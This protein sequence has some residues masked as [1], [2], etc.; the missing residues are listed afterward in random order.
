MEENTIRKI[1]E[2]YI[3]SEAAPVVTQWILENRVKFRITKN[4]TTKLGD[5]KYD[6]RTKKHYISVNKGLNTYAFLITT[7]HEFA[8]LMAFKEFGFK[9][10][11]HGKEW[12]YCM[13]EL[14]FDF[15][16]LL[17]KDI[18]LALNNYLSNPKA[19]S[20][21]DTALNRV[22][23]RY[24][25]RAQLW[26]EEIPLQTPFQLRGKVYV[27]EQKRRTRYLC[28]ET[29]SGKKYLIHSQA[30]VNVVEG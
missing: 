3:P 8:H 20:C 28:R 10:K 24:D 15:L 11:P 21:S 27:A 14:M 6:H 18:Q 7:T 26:L 19:S 29:E 12:K 4:R 23:R 13:Q 22:L 25:S 9:I 16:P 30:E 5:Y 17:P 2:K 1:L